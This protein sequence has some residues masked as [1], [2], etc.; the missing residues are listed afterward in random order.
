[1]QRPT[2]FFSKLS[3]NVKL[4]YPTGKD[5]GREA[6]DPTVGGRVKNGFGESKIPSGKMPTKFNRD[7]L[8][9]QALLNAKEERK[10]RMSVLEAKIKS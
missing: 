9:V 7:A 3:W 4:T 8:K 5:K 10:T 2:F 1:L 6:S